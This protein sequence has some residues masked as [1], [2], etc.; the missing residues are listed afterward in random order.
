LVEPVSVNV[1][2]VALVRLPVPVIC[3]AK[4][5]VPVWLRVV[6]PPS[7]TMPEPVTCATVGVALVKLTVP[8]A[9]TIEAAGIEPATLSVPPLATLMFVLLVSEPAEPM[10]SVPP[11]T[12]VVP[13]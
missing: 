11:V 12:V 8:L 7:E 10:V 4:V 13:V 1:P 5:L 3:P 2:P 9:V 6:V